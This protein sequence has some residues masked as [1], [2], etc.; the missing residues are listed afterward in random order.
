MKDELNV[1]L[2]QSM[3]MPTPLIHITAWCTGYIT[4]I[5]INHAVMWMID[6]R[7]GIEAMFLSEI[8]A[9]T[10]CYYHIIMITLA[11]SH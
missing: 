7:A 2:S 4:S 10:F 3:H 6:E 8:D 5:S 11:G 1:L 9:L